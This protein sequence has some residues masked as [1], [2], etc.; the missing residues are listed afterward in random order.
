MKK[1]EGGAS[2]RKKRAEREKEEGAEE[3]RR[4]WIS[5]RPPRRRRAR[6]SGAQEPRRPARERE[7]GRVD[8]S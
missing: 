1:E 4:A 5:G 6:R 7:R 2:V 3:P 8:E